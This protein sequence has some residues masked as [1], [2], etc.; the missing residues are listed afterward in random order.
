MAAPD[1]FAAVKKQAQRALAVV[2]DEIRR[3]EAELEKLMEQADQWRAAIA[4]TGAATRRRAP[5]RRSKAGTKRSAAKKGSS[6]KRTNW[7]EV[8]KGLPKTF[9]VDDVMKRPGAKARGR[10]Q[11]YP[12]LT[13]WMEGKKVKRVGKGKYQKL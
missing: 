2:M 1:P 4:G 8:L 10:A 7:D 3:R 5:G 12:T 11:V 6:G 13:R 9:T